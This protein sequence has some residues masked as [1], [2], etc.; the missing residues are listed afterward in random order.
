MHVMEMTASEISTDFPQQVIEYF[1]SAKIEDVKAL[2]ER[3]NR[4]DSVTNSIGKFVDKVEK[5]VEI[6]AQAA[7]II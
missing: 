6:E 1:N 3:L 2:I 4:L 7:K 5:K